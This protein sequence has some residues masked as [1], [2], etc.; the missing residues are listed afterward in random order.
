MYAVAGVI[1]TRVNSGK[2]GGGACNIVHQRGQFIGA[3]H[4]LPNNP[5]LI[6]EMTEAAQNARANGYYGFRSYCKPGRSTRIGGNCYGTADAERFVVLD[7]VMTAEDVDLQSWQNIQFAE[8]QD[9]DDDT[10]AG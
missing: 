9:L 2:W 3:W 7:P 4:V 8:D 10:G 5:R 6:S 1:E